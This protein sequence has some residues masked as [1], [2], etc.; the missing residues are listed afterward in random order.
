MS[1]VSLALATF[2]MMSD[3]LVANLFMDLLPGTVYDSVLLITLYLAVLFT[4]KV[5]LHEITNYI[6]TRSHSNAAG[7]RPGLYPV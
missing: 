2:C 5:F 7:F 6:S 3:L 4:L 1:S